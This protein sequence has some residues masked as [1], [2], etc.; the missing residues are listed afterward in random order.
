MFRFRRKPH[1]HRSNRQGAPLLEGAALLEHLN[2]TRPIIRLYWGCGVYVNF[3]DDICSGAGHVS[4][5]WSTLKVSLQ[6]SR[7]GEPDAIILCDIPYWLRCDRCGRFFA[8]NGFGVHHIDWSRSLKA[9]TQR[10]LKG[11]L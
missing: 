4:V 2:E 8:S 5:R 6:P 7:E 11:R 9:I 1:Q 3:D 10:M